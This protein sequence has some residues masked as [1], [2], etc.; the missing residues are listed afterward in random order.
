M[1][2]PLQDE[3]R[4]L[5]LVSP[6]RPLERKRRESQTAVEAV[7]ARARRDTTTSSEISSDN[8]LDASLFKRKQIHSTSMNKTSRGVLDHVDQERPLQ[9]SVANSSTTTTTTGE[10]HADSDEDSLA[11]GFSETADSTSLMDISNPLQS[12][13]G[14]LGNLARPIGSRE[15]SPVRRAAPPTIL[16]ALPPSRPISTV[17]PVSLLS[18]ALR[19]RFAKPVSPFERFATLSGSGSPDP[20]YVKIYLPASTNAD[21]PLEIILRKTSDE[22]AQVTVAEAI[23]FSLWR[24]AEEKVR[25][26]IAESRMNVNWWTLRIVEDGEVDFDFP[27]LSRAKPMVDLT[28]NNNRGQRGRVR[29]KP[30]DEFALVE[31]TAAQ[32]RE[33][34]EATPI[35]SEYAASSQPPILEEAPASQFQETESTVTNPGTRQN[36]ITGPRYTRANRQ[37]SM[38]ALDA[39][40]EPVSHSTPRTGATKILNVHFMDNE[41]KPRVIPIEVTTDTY[42]AEV[43][44]QVCKKLNVDKAQHVLK[45]TKTTTIVPFDRTVEALGVERSSLDL[46]RRRF[47]GDGAFGLPGSPNS[48]TPNAP[49]LVHAVESP[50]KMK[51]GGSI[52]PLAQQTDLIGLGLAVGTNANYRRYNVIRKQPMSFTPSHPRILALD[53]EYMHVMPSDA[54]KEKLFDTQ[55]GKITTV[56][57]SN[58]VGCKVNRKHPKTFRVVVFR[59]RETKRYDFEASSAGEAAEIVEEIKKG[60]EP[61]RNHLEDDR[62]QG[63]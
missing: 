23:G 36:P 42:I 21:K 9:A 47:I 1:R 26:A 30:W 28:S 55:Q 15:H 35:Y 13:T 25:P 44:D 19:S 38:N 8:E 56:H 17:Q 61:F 11:S 4:P 57:F 24:Y 5:E 7:K 10:R 40:S 46:I 2:S 16:K 3:D 45:V 18:M 39:P 6:S 34:E 31:A 63:G 22:G 33:N 20:L 12:S 50:R 59:E 29:D 52:H 32:F 54:A 27:A 51:R 49:L 37:N 14:A 60:V 53:S 58:V 41:Y 43:F 62:V 48:S